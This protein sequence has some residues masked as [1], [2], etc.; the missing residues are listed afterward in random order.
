MLSYIQPI[1]ITIK[2]FV[3]EAKNSSKGIGE[4]LISKNL[5]LI[6]QS[7]NQ[8]LWVISSADFGMP[9]ANL[10]EF[11]DCDEEQL[12]FLQKK[13]IIEIIN[14]SVF[15]KDYFKTE[16]LKSAEPLAY[17]NIIKGIIKFLEAQLPLKPS[18]R[19]LKL[20]RLTIRN[21]IERFNNLLK[22][23]QP[24]GIDKTKTSYMNILGYSK[25]FKTSWDGFDDIIM[26]KIFQEEPKPEETKTKPEEEQPQPVETAKNDNDFDMEVSSLNLAR[27][28]K[29]K[30]LYSEA[31]L[32]YSDALS[33][34][35]SKGSVPILSSTK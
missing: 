22:K 28:L 20:S 30:Y 29:N 5:S 15:V 31:L 23:S 8:L 26:P 9:K 11:P 2:E 7:Y 35:I 19:E 24:S 3:A 21:E 27:M 1:N 6:P 18:L 10:L 13:G 4:M 12:I 32:Q 14:D 17:N 33:N 25:Q 16:I 34:T